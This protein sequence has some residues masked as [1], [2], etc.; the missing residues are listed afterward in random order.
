MNLDD[1][2]QKSIIASACARNSHIEIHRHR[3]SGELLTFG[4][5]MLHEHEGQLGV[6][7]KRID[8]KLDCLNPGNVVTVYVLEGETLYSFLAEV[9]RVNTGIGVNDETSTN[10]IWIRRLGSVAPR[11]RRDAYRTLIAGSHNIAVSIHHAHEDIAGAAPIGAAVFDGKLVEESATGI[12]VL[13]EGDVTRHFDRGMFVHVSFRSTKDD[14][15]FFF[16]AKVRHGR[17]LHGSLHTRIGLQ[18]IAWPDRARY[19]HELYRY[20][21][22]VTDIAREQRRRLAG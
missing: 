11:Q 17:T 15:P 6:A 9:C 14:E 20:E 3:L 5:R 12:G 19:G 8:T 16:L 2:T 21:H 1:A 7:M 18:L 22:F 13:L 4:G 10:G